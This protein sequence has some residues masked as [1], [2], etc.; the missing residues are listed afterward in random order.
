MGDARKAYE[1]AAKLGDALLEARFLGLGS[2]DHKALFQ[3]IHEPLSEAAESAKRY[4]ALSPNLSKSKRE[5]WND[6]QEYLRNF[7]EFSDLKNKVQ[8]QSQILSIKE[9]T[10]KAR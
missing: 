1:K 2:G 4:I 10:T 5:D 7:A 6:R 8:G 9:V 3:E